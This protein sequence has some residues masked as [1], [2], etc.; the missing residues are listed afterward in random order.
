MSV[1]QT[2]LVPDAVAFHAKDHAEGVC[3]VAAV[4]LVAVS[5]CPD[6]GAVAALT[7]TVVVALFKASAYHVVF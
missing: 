4:P 1:T 6:D 3:H 7:L 5:T 2:Q